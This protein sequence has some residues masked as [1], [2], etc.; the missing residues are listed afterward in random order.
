[1]ETNA[2]SAEFLGDETEA[3]IT[4]RNQLESQLLRLPAELRNQIYAYVGLST[5]IR[6]FTLL[7]SSTISWDDAKELKFQRPNLL[8]TCKQVRQEATTLICKHAVFDLVGCDAGLLLIPRRSQDFFEFVTS[9]RIARDFA[10]VKP[11][12]P[13][14]S[15]NGTVYK[16]LT[17]WL[18]NLERVYVESTGWT[19]R[20]GRIRARASLKSRCGNDSLEVIIVDK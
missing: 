14:A 11:S 15:A 5:T 10:M 2:S 16:P 13:K 9:I 12:K 7:W 6:V 4:V 8:S 20:G 17:R 1:M 3:N 19:H 18:P